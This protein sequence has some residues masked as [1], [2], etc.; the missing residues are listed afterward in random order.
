MTRPDF[1]SP[2]SELARK[3]AEALEKL[4]NAGRNMTPDDYR[5]QRKSYALGAAKTEED[6]EELSAWWDRRHGVTS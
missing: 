4:A 1:M 3:T 6:R 5:A 2:D